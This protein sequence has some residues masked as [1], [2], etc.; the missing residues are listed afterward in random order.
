MPKYFIPVI[1]NGS[2]LVHS[3]YAASLFAAGVYLAKKHP[4]F[5]MEVSCITY[6]YP[7]QA[8]NIATNQFMQSDCDT[9]VVIDGDETFLPWHLEALLSHKEPLVFASYCRKMRGKHLTLQY[10]PVTPE[11]EGPLVEVARA[12]RG[13]MAVKREVFEAFKSHV[14]TYVDPDTDA[15][16]YAYWQSDVGYSS[17]DFWFCDKWRE[18]GGKILVDSRFTVNHKGWVT[19]PMEDEL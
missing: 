19:F 4:S 16:C 11:R 5:E 14:P 7:V 13:F 9:M 2:Q 12:A 10:L 6:A 3:E 15:T 18:L 17:E 1:N 8:M